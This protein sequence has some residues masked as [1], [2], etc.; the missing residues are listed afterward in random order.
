MAEEA[1]PAVAYLLALRQSSGPKSAAAAAPAHSNSSGEHPATSGPQS[2]PRGAEKRRSPRYKCDGKAE[3]HQDGTDLRTWA[4]FTDVS[5]HGCYLEVPTTF[6]VGTKLHLKMEASGVQLET[7]GEVRVNY[8]GLGMGVAFVDMTEDNL[9]RL[10]QMLQR[11]MPPCMIL[12]PGV[13]SALPST[14]PLHGVPLITDPERAL[15]AL[16]DCF[17]TRQTL[18]REDFLRILKNSQASDTRR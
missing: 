11:V 4:T 9:A 12:G 3:V 7:G 2:H 1:N 5:L 17:E 6:P 14:N 10:K 13:A 15:Q 16:I 18:A 8:P